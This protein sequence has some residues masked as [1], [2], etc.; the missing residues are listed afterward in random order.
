MKKISFLILFTGCLQTIKAQ[1]NPRDLDTIG[2]KTLDSIIVNTYLVNAKVKYL[3]DVIGVN[4]YS[5]KKTNV[6]YLDP[7]RSNLAQ[8]V[9]RTTFA[10][11]P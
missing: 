2:H 8:N 3:A 5:G 11:I 7:S 6:I 9:T 1:T 10:K 4:I